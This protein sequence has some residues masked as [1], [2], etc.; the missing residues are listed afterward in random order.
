MLRPRLLLAAAVAAAAA[1]GSGV[2]VSSTTTA[3]KRPDYAPPPPDQA[4]VEAPGDVPLPKADDPAERIAYVRAGSVFLWTP[5]NGDDLRVTVR[6]TG[7]PDETPA[8]SPHGDAVAFSSRRD[9]PAKLFVAA[10]D[11]TGTRV[12]TDGADGG[13]LDPA[14]SPDGRSLVFVRGRPGERRDLFV[15]D[16]DAG[17]TSRRLLEGA[18]NDPA[19]VGAPAWSPD[20]TAIVFSADRGEGLGTG[21]FLVK[22]DGSGLRRLTRPPSSQRWVRD[23]HPAWSPDGKR[24]A[25]AS[26]RHAATEDDAGDLDL[27]VVDLASGELTRLTRDPGVADD[28]TYS[29]D[30]KRIYFTSTRSAPRDYS[31]ELYAMPATGGEQRRLTRDEVPQNS[32]PSAGRVP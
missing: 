22:P 23:L 11:G 31:T 6:A 7:A 10:L 18:D 1:C 16:F 15:L 21:L 25:F 27:Y 30:G 3:H 24:V 32:A 2:P 19:R 4:V 17:E 14:W 28:P 9:G 26:N 12:V 20:G 8:L 29:P 5:Q 13:D